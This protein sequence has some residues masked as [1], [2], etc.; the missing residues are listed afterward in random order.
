MLWVGI[1]SKIQF[2]VTM[3]YKFCSVA[4]LGHQVL[5][6]W[7]DGV[8]HLQDTSACTPQHQCVTSE[9]QTLSN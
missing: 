7:N 6:Y 3:H 2:V 9:T 8:C 4:L 5:D 1:C